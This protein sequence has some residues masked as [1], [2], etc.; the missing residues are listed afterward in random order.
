MALG[1]AALLLLCSCGTAWAVL[2][3]VQVASRAEYFSVLAS[4][5]F[6]AKYWERRPVLF[7]TGNAFTDVLPLPKVLSG[8]Y[9]GPEH[10][11]LPH[12]Y[13]LNG[14]LFNKDAVLRQL[15]WANEVCGA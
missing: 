7:K 13:T 11:K 10:L 15:N 12:L 6:K 5:E 1:A 8:H 9:R 14:T 4:A 3:T 2:D